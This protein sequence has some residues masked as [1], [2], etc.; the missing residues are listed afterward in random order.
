MVQPRC[1]IRFIGCA[2]VSPF[3]WFLCL[4]SRQGLLSKEA[5]FVVGCIELAAQRQLLSTDRREG[6]P[7]Q[8]LFPAD[9]TQNILE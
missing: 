3:W 7:R 2:L 6:A 1:F 8:G 9:T 4:F 5:L